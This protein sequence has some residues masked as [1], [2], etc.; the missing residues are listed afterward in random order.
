MSRNLDFQVNANRNKPNTYRNINIECPFCNFY[1]N[2]GDNKVITRDGNQMLIE[3][4]FPTYSNAHQTVLIENSTCEFNLSTYNDETLSDVIAFGFSNWFEMS[5]SN[6]YTSVVFFKNHGLNSGGSITHPH[7]QI[8]GLY[9]T[10]YKQSLKNSDFEGLLIYK[11][12]NVDWNISTQPKSEFYEFNVIIPK[13]EIEEYLSNNANEAFTLFCK[14][15]QRTTHFILTELNPRNKSYN[16]CF[17]EFEDKVI[18][19]IIPRGFGHASVTS[20][21]LLGYGLSQVPNDIQEV[22][23]KLKNHH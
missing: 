13:D 11:S 21:Y 3:N 5:R 6:K 14:C 10:D 16:L 7:M 9:D 1:N 8:V 20:P 18:A 19:K 23:T 4:K 15:I 2:K 12:T 17:Y 22:A